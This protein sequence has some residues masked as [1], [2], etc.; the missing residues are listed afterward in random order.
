MDFKEI[1][2]K[3]SDF[4]KKIWAWLKPYLLKIHNWRKRIW[5]KYQLTKILLLLGLV[6]VLV[7]SVYLFYLAKSANVETLQSSLK[8]VTTIYDKDGDEAGNLYGQKGNFVELNQIS[9]N[10]VDALLSTEDK[11]FYQHSGFDIRGIGRAVLGILKSGG[12]TGGGSTLTQ[13]LAKNAYLSLDQTLNRK[14]KELFLA[15]EIEKEYTKDEILEMYLNNAYFANGV[16]GVE[17]A[18][19]K[20]FGVNAADVT[21][22]EAAVIVGML[23]GP[24]YYNPIDNYDKAIL[25]RDTVLE[26]MVDNGKLAREEA[27]RLQADTLHLT[28]NYAG[29]KNVNQYPYYFDAVINEAESRAKISDDDLLNKGYK[30]Y[31]TMDQQYQQDMDMT[32]ANDGLFPPNAE[33]GALVQGASIAINPKTGGIQAVVGGRGEYAF[34]DLN[35]A[36]QSSLSPG[37]T[38]KPLAVYTLAL[39]NGYQPDSLLKDDKLSFYNV[40]NADKY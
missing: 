5:K 22:D 40:E 7:T 32:F 4:L 3:I 23:K 29:G 12:I 35:R 39:E 21:V 14:A 1:M 31:T 17:D 2:T 13:Q 10:I 28:D 25:R 19:H 20:Y 16:W 33:D 27:D 24:G 18:A 26:L 30:I 6:V 15:I 38:M 8:Q 37:S 36:T 11:R 9:P 34:R